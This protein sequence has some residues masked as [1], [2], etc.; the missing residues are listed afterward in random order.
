M[1]SDLESLP[2]LRKLRLGKWRKLPE[3]T[4][5]SMRSSNKKRDPVL[6]RLVRGCVGIFVPF[7]RIRAQ[8][9]GHKGK[10]EWFPGISKK[11]NWRS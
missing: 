1:L 3:V 11:S 7:T 6:K 2:L 5:T 4:V 8:E 9:E 10:Q